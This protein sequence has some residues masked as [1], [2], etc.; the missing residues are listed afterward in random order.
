MG[1]DFSE[2]GWMMMS[3][4]SGYTVFLLYRIHTLL[5]LI[6][7]TVSV[8]FGLRFASL[9]TYLPASQRT[10]QPTNQPA[11]QP[12]SQPASHH[13]HPS[14]GIRG[15][16]SSALHVALL[17]YYC[18]LPVCHQVYHKYEKHHLEW[19]SAEFSFRPGKKLTSLSVTMFIVQASLNASQE[20][21]LIYAKFERI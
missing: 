4:I 5:T 7:P 3:I 17:D 10:N 20:N 14:S 19:K 16:H 18:A 6:Q 15:I 1:S 11:S 21:E 9:W 12:V 8:V 13:H 2:G